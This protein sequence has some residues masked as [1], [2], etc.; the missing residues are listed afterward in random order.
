MPI[1]SFWPISQQIY[2]VMWIGA[3]GSDWGLT[4]VIY[5]KIYSEA[6]INNQY[7]WLKNSTAE[8]YFIFGRA[9]LGW[10][11]SSLLRDATNIHRLPTVYV[12]TT[13]F[14]L[15]NLWI[16]EPSLSILDWYI[17]RTY[18]SDGHTNSNHQKSSLSF[19]T[20]SL[21]KF[22]LHSYVMKRSWQSSSSK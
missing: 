22:F 6:Y 18:L 4:V 8:L 16:S 20:I 15:E 17:T 3:Q 11:F 12:I 14:M 7:I 13:H 9:S 19:C 21:T 10:N 1:V 5:E 2:P